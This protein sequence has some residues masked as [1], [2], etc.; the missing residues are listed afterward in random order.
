MFLL[1]R[2]ELGH[3]FHLLVVYLD[4]VRSLVQGQHHLQIFGVVDTLYSVVVQQVVLL[5]TLTQLHLELGVL[6]LLLH[7]HQLPQ[8]VLEQ[9]GVVHLLVSLRHYLMEHVFESHQVVWTFLEWEFHYLKHQ[10][11]KMLYFGF[12]LR[13]VLEL[14]FDELKLLVEDQSTY[15]GGRILS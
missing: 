9:R 15:M 6:L 8:N 10:Y 13:Q 5:L 1:L 2:V 14:M 4:H 7:R 11:Q 3:V 12:V